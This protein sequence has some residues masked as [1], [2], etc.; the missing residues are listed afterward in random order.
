LCRSLIAFCDEGRRRVAAKQHAVVHFQI[1]QVENRYLE[2]APRFAGFL[3]RGV[4]KRL[5]PG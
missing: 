1:D 5:G 4:A 3:Y 2:E